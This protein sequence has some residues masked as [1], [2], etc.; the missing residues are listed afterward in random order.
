[1]K[2]PQADE[3]VLVDSVDID[4]HHSFLITL[5]LFATSVLAIFYLS[6]LFSLAQLVYR[7]HVTP[8]DG[9]VF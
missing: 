6:C 8:N 4:F 9:K 1:V 2:H 3:V 5:V 7:E